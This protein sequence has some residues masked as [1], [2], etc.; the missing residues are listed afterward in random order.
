MEL[1][2]GADSRNRSDFELWF[3]FKYAFVEMWGIAVLVVT[4]SDLYDFSQEWKLPPK[5]IKSLS[6][7]LRL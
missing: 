7:K 3:K 6:L 4:S 2:K 5:R 1:E